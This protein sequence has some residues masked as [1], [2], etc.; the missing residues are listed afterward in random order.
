MATSAFPKYQLSKFHDRSGKLQS[1]F[2]TY[3]K[4]EYDAILKEWTPAEV[5][6]AVID[7]K[8]EAFN[9]EHGDQ[10]GMPETKMCPIHNVKM[11]YKEGK[12]GPYYSHGNK[13]MGYCNGKPKVKSY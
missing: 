1:V 7:K 13:E 4:E 5:K 11:Y 12:F 8:V 3:V 9:Q 6:E 10:S 2:R